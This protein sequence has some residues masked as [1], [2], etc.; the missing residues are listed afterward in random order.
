MRTENEIAFA[1]YIGIDGKNYAF[2]MT[3]E[4]GKWKLTALAPTP[5]G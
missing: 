3:Q 2:P 5:M 1:L 4:G